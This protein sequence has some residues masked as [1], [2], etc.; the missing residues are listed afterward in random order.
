MKKEGV[1]WPYNILYRAKPGIDERP[2]PARLPIVKK[3]NPHSDAGID[4]PDREW[5]PRE[6]RKLKGKIT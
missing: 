1:S 5:L 4:I 2:F 3:T 6:K